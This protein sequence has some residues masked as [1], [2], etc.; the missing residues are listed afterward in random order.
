MHLRARDGRCR[1][2]IFG[3]KHISRSFATQSLVTKP[4]ELSLISVSKLYL[5][6]KV[7]SCP[8]P[9]LG[10]EE[11]AAPADMAAAVGPRYVSAMA[12]A[13]SSSAHEVLIRF[14]NHSSG[15]RC[16]SLLKTCFGCLQ[17]FTTT[18]TTLF[19]CTQ[20][21]LPRAIQLY[22]KHKNFDATT[23]SK[24][25]ISSMVSEAQQ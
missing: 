21:Y 15:F 19:P 8:V 2:F 17:G 1:K 14:N 24:A 22:G 10:N 7:F 12:L 6:S 5:R 23:T 13:T 3:T 20:D 4:E 11:A 18:E 25:R 16:I 9:C